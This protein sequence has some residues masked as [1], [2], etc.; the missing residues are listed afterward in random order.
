MLNYVVTGERAISSNMNLC[1]ISL[2]FFHFP[3][4]MGIVR[5]ENGALAIARDQ[6]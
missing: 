5:H 3:W 6:Q 1:F 4:I 2:S